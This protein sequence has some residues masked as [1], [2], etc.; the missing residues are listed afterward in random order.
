VP[1]LTTTEL[2][3]YADA[4]SG[5]FLRAIDA[6]TPPEQI[7]YTLTAPPEGAELRLR[8]A[9][10]SPI[11]PDVPLGTGATFTQADIQSGRLV[12]VHGGTS[13]ST[14]FSGTLRDGSDATPSEPQS[15]AVQFY[16]PAAST[17]DSLSPAQ[18]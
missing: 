13:L 6:D 16:R 12:L 4:S 14:S 8:N 11:Q 17:L 5:V 10:S 18:R 2:T 1:V 9:Q 15:V 7:T 3:A